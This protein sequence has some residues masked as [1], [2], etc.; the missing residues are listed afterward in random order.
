[1]V[2]K[3]N[4]GRG[5][6]CVRLTY[7]HNES[8][9]KPKKG[10]EKVQRSTDKSVPVASWGVC[11]EWL[12]CIVIKSSKRAFWKCKVQQINCQCHIGYYRR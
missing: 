8:D 7:D 2:E 10:E 3:A 12:Y 4:L 11:K 5:Q 6:A 1:M 9:G